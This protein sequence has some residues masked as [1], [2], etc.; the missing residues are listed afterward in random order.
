MHNYV[1]VAVQD[2]SYIQGC[3][4]V[5]K[6]S[7]Y[8]NG[9]LWSLIFVLKLYLG[10]LVDTMFY[11]KH[12]ARLSIFIHTDILVPVSEFVVV[13]ILSE[14]WLVPTTVGTSLYICMMRT[15][16]LL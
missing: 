6:S 11:I 9:N 1:S 3:A 5:C 7:G 12:L 13:V 2:S 8:I 4:Q 15:E 14:W 16:P 10:F